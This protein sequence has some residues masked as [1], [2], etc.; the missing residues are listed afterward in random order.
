MILLSNILFSAHQFSTIWGECNIT[1]HGDYYNNQEVE[2]IVRYKINKLVPILPPKGFF[3]ADPF[4]VE[5]NNEFFLFFE[6]YS[7]KKNKGNISCGLLKNDKLTNIK[8][9]I[10]SKNHYSYPFIF[11]YENKFYFPVLIY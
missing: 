7:Y 6:N 8:D 2:S 5:R 3:Y 1:N 10:S 9:I 4:L 11:N